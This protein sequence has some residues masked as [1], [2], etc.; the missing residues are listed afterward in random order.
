MPFA[1]N[2]A[3]CHLAL[4][5]PEYFTNK[6]N[7]AIWDSTELEPGRTIPSMAG[8]KFVLKGQTALDSHIKPSEKAKGVVSLTGENPEEI[9]L[10]KYDVVIMNPPFTRHERIPED[11]KAV[12]FDRFKDYADYLHG[13]MGYFGYFVL[14]ADRFL[15]DGGKMALV[16]PAT[17]LRVESS[18]G[19]RKLLAQKYYV[20][21]II[22]T[23]HRSA[24]SE[25]VRFREVL[26]IARKFEPTNTTK[27]VVTV[28]KRLPATLTEA[29]AMADVIKSSQTNWEDDRMIVRVHD[30]SKLRATTDN[31]FKYIAVSDLS[32]IDLL[33]EL[34]SSD[35]LIALHSLL[36]TLNAEVLRGIETARGGKIQAL[37]ITQPGRAIKKEDVWVIEES[38][39]NYLKVKDRYIE[40]TLTIPLT[41]VLHTLRR[42]ALIDKIDVSGDLDYV[43]IN[44]FPNVKKFLTTGVMTFKPPQGF[45][46][47]WKSYV[48]ERLSYLALVRRAD[49]S[50]PGT[51]L[52]AFYSDVP[53]APPGVTWSVKVKDREAAKI[54]AL[55]FNSTINILQALVNRKETRGAFLQIDEYVLKEAFVPDLAKLTQDEKT[56]LRK[57]FNS[58]KSIRFPSVFEQLKCRHEARKLIDK[59]WLSVLGYKGDVEPIL[60]KL[61]TSLAREIEHLKK[62]MEERD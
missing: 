1:A 43:V 61:Y 20:E 38:T 37:T 32:L 34:L 27:T 25:S 56:L 13:Q 24:F 41:S 9:N 54:L 10:K 3:A 29:H 49:I 42:V 44:E 51:C 50:A 35:R 14:L 19:L 58:V 46:N 36:A 57:T 7:I 48:E 2:V 33:E 55:W 21:H 30:Y 26:L 17:A 39:E 31:W 40:R 28:L 6:V 5:S 15:K 60:T 23:W 8:L 4:Q 12:L 62:L 47:R 45:W 11:Y 18:K 53:M 22:T 59:T 16:L 52:L